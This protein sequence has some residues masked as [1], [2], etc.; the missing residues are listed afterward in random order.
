MGGLRVTK[1][2]LSQ[3]CEMRRVDFFFHAI[4]GLVWVQLIF[5]GVFL[6]SD[7]WV[8]LTHLPFAILCFFLSC[9]FVT[10]S[11]HLPVPG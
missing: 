3:P 8:R 7:L 9:W 1:V 6:F 4:L 5:Q 10:F 11:V 2:K